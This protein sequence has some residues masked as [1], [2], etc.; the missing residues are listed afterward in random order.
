MQQ[1]SVRKDVIEGLVLDLLK[2]ELLTPETVLA[3]LEDVKAE[4]EHHEEAGA[5]HL[6]D[7]DRKIQKVEWELS[8]LT[9]G[10]QGGWADRTAY[11]GVEGGRGAKSGYGGRET[12]VKGVC[13]SWAATGNSWRD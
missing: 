12:S 3:L 5:G 10:H 11:E 4:L 8:N 13:A 1:W 9:L 6:R 2:A 7:L